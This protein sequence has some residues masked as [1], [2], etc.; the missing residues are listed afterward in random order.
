MANAT[1]TTDEAGLVYNGPVLIDYV[2]TNSEITVPEGI[3]EICE[4][5]FSGNTNIT[6]VRFPDTVKT[7]G[8][9]AFYGCENLTVVDMPHEL[10]RIGSNV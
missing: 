6:K 5:A 3:E 8:D 10:T 2:G 4:Y 1:A 9:Y 7:I